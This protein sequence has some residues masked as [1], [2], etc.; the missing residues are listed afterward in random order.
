MAMESGYSTNG[1]TAIGGPQSYY[2]LP[3]ASG[4]NTRDN[5][6]APPTTF[7]IDLSN[8]IS[9]MSSGYYNKDVL[10]VRS[11]DNGVQRLARRR[12]RQPGPGR[13]RA[14]TGSGFTIVAGTTVT[15][16]NYSVSATGAINSTQVQPGGSGNRLVLQLPAGT[17]LPADYYRLYMPNQVEP[18]GADT[19][20][21]DIYGNQLDGEFLGNPTSQGS[22]EFQPDTQNNVTLPMY[23]DEMSDG[24][25]RQDAMSGDGVAG[26]A[27]LTGFAVVPYGNVVYTR[28]DYVEN[29]LL[30]NG[31][32]LSDGSMARPYPVLAPEGNPSSTLATNPTHNPNLGLNNPAFFQPA[33]FNYSYDYSGDGKFEQSSLYAASQLAYKGP[34]IVVAEPGLPSR[35]PITGQVSQASFSVVAPAGNTSGAGGS[36]SV[37]FDTTLVFQAGAALKLQGSSLFVQNQGSCP[38]GPGHAGQPG[39][40]HLLQR[41]FGRWRHQRQPRHPAARR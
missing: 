35:S 11:A 20:I 3:P 12:L 36:I 16:Y 4:T 32:G 28:P 17:T 6:A 40:V 10:L 29:P 15:L 9:Y 13:P 7:V 41:R 5:V 2:E 18:N 14:A 24:T 38:P 19:R 37:P 21:Y 25:F 22:T 30:P 1:S 23:Q 33:N 39:D 26:G 31:A 34:V 8:P 27:Y